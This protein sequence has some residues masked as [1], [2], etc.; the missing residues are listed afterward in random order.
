[1]N[2][3]NSEDTLLNL[4]NP[5]ELDGKKNINH[6]ENSED[7]S[8]KEMLGAKSQLNTE[9]LEYN[10][11][12]EN[13][14]RS[15]NTIFALEDGLTFMTFG[16][17]AITQD[18]FSKCFQRLPRRKF[19]FYDIIFPYY[20]LGWFFRY[21]GL[22]MYRLW[23][24]MVATVIFFF[25][26]PIV[27]YFKNIKLQRLLFLFYCRSFV[28]AFGSKI[29]FHGEK[30]ILNEPHIFVANHTSIVDY[31]I[32]SSDKFS[33]AAV[34]QQQGGL[35]GFL[36]KEVLTLNGSL[37]FN[38]NEKRD[39]TFISKKMYD[40]VHDP[41]RSPLLIFPEGVCVN[42]EYTV[43]FH[44][45]AFELDAWVCPVAIKY[46]KSKFDPYWHTREQTFTYHILY[47][48]TRWNLVADVYYLPPVKINPGE[49]SIQFSNR[50][51]NMISNKA[52]LK[53]L[54]WD[55]YMKNFAPPQAKLEKMAKDPQD[56]F[57]EVLRNRMN[58][59]P[60][61]SLRR[62]NSISLCDLSSY[63]S[64]I[65]MITFDNS[66][67]NDTTDVMNEIIV[68]LLNDQN[69]SSFIH[70]INSQQNDLVNSWQQ[71]SDA[72]NTRQEYINWRAWSKHIIDEGEVEEQLKS[73][74]A[75]REWLMSTL[76]HRTGRWGDF[77]NAQKENEKRKFNPLSGFR[78][79]FYNPLSRL[80][81]QGLISPITEKKLYKFSI[82]MPSLN[83]I[84]RS[85]HNS[86]KD[87]NKNPN[88][89][90]S[91]EKIENKN[92]NRRRP[93]MNKST[94]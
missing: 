44:K 48:M 72:Q 45:G 14:H 57:G 67:E 47:L 64:S 56:R 66:K 61:Y 80:N 22:F 51:K 21:L 20:V 27:N 46:D 78:I 40:H 31:L 30:P 65:P 90:Q 87:L 75:Y 5:K 89:E 4:E 3:N 83:F 70:T 77:L 69:Q 42:N 25:F 6:Q 88:D 68:T 29:R 19:T 54:S 50:V 23:L 92:V 1:M 76:K 16:A 7:L 84:R 41:S 60:Q 53:N 2:E 34:A 63:R 8:I 49:T 33:H 17:K 10:K 37:M 58:E 12:T 73:K 94:E 24:L 62:S 9:T 26:L 93:W 11:L 15:K 91:I 13:Y 59:K 36:Q 39:R 38:R 52:G 28:K 86:T 82:P 71:Y 18:E 35:Y 32:L 85:R 55:G 79:P 74:K 81:H 43:L